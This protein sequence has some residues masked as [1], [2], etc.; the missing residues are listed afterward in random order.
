MART[1]LAIDGD[2]IA[3]NAAAG[4]QT[5]VNLGGD[6]DD[7]CMWHLTANE[8]KARE[9]A[10]RAI[11]MLRDFSEADDV[12]VMLSDASHNW[13]QDILPS[14]KANRKGK[15]RPIILPQMRQY[16]RDTFDAI[17]RPG[18]EGDDV[19]GIY[20]G[21]KSRYPKLIIATRDKDLKTIPGLHMR[22]QDDFPVTFEVTP[23]EAD[24]FFWKQGLIGD[25]TDGYSGCPGFGPTAAEEWLA[26]PYELV[27]EPYTITKGKNKGTEGT[28][29]TKH[30]ASSWWAG[31]RSIYAKA[32]YDEAFALTQFR[33]ARILRASDY[34]FTNKQPILWSPD[35]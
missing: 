1:T 29:W 25:V 16:L 24:R 35:R 7:D 14:Y 22:M 19:L 21:L 26:D 17:E 27:P 33:V 28:R 30:P 20:A 11:E 18:L 15:P 34:D 9:N 2:I 5:A 8:T 4:S 23:E 6:S 32:G 31:A 3:Y 13:R 10:D 12:L